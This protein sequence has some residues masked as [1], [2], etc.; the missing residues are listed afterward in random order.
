MN[1]EQILIEQAVTYQYIVVWVAC[2]S[3]AFM[4]LCA[5]CSSM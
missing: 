5:Y 3:L 4:A 1:I 2:C